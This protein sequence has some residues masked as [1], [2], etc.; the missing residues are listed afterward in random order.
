MNRLARL[1]FLVS[2]LVATMTIS[3]PAVA[4]QAGYPLLH[5][6]PD[7]HD[8][9]SL[10]RGA[11]TYMNYCLGCHSLQY[12]RYE[13][14]ADDL[15]VPHDLMLQH[16][17]FDPDKQIGSPID[18]T[19]TSDH[20]KSWFGAVPPDLTLY[21][22][23]KGGPD[24]LYTYLKT[25]YEDPARP[26]GVNN[27]VFENVGMPHALLELQGVQRKVCKEIPRLAANGG[28]MRDPLT[29][30][31]ITEKTCGEEL[32]SRGYSPLELVDGT[33]SLSA[34]EYDQVVFDLSNFLY[35]V[36]DPSR[37]ERERLGVYVLLFLAFFFVFTYLL[38][39][40]YTREFH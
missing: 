26:L 30:I 31:P 16:L 24:Y 22:S 23:L 33:G 17:V 1:T 7:L 29:S 27:L 14:T 39:R 12:Q 3:V 37:L 32:V 6:E 15:G 2:T 11:R 21:T 19:I 10:Q 36:A 5:M 9:A 25:F 28:E 38:G 34:Q 13:R 40:E 35:Y 4:A 20:A 8:K 18:N